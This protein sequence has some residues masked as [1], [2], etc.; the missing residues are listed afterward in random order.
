MSNTQETSIVFRKVGGHSHNGLTSSLIDTTKYSLFDFAPNLNGTTNTAR[1]RFQ[2]NN[3]QIIKKFI[4]DTIEER[5]LNPQGIEIQA[6]VIT[7]RHIAANTITSNEL[8][9]NLVLVNNIIRSNTFNGTFNANGTIATSGTIGWAIANSGA[10]VFNDVTIRGNIIGGSSIDINSGMFTVNSSGVVT[11]KSGKI[12]PVN[13]TTTSM[14]SQGS[15]PYLNSNNN[16]YQLDQ[17]GDINIYSNPGSDVGGPHEGEFHKTL[18]AGE[19]IWISKHT[20]SSFTDAVKPLEVFVGNMYGDDIVEFGLRVNN[21]YRFRAQSNGNVSLTGTLNGYGFTTGR[22]D[23]ANQLVHTDGNGY[24]QVGYINS[25]QGYNENNN[26]SPDRVWGSNAGSDSYLRAYRTSALSVGS[27]DVAY[28]YAG[29]SISTGNGTF[30][31]INGV[32]SPLRAARPYVNGEGLIAFFDT[33][34]NRAAAGGIRWGTSNTDLVVWDVASDY[35]L[36]TKIRDFDDGVEL[37]RQIRPVKFNWKSNDNESH[38]F[39]AQ[40]LI[41]VYP[42]AVLEPN[43]DTEYYGVSTLKLVPLMAAAIKDLIEKNDELEARLQILEGV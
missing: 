9:A 35:R 33:D 32:P 40:E 6:N 34:V 14:N 37:F 42:M 11:A 5:V 28:G 15:S 13:I 30:T 36:K 10:A 8:S 7:A 25:L 23:G 17:Y 18:L 39:I 20:S 31:T 24:L 29:T 22:H 38:G 16:Y 12:G 4:V 1:R 19:Y 26:Y 3:Q 2:D 21:V 41:E 43:A 27:A